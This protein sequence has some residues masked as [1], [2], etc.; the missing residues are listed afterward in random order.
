MGDMYLYETSTLTWS[1]I[2]VL[3]G[4]A[5]AARFAHGFTSIDRK[6]YLFA[7]QGV[8]GKKRHMNIKLSFMKQAARNVQDEI[9][10]TH[11]QT[12]KL[13]ELVDISIFFCELSNHANHANFFHINNRHCFVKEKLEQGKL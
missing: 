10:S 7:G 8:V 3:N 12:C 5:P 9:E 6:L 2:T 1:N 11:R 4:I 13:D